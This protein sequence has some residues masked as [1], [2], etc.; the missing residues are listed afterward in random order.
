MPTTTTDADSGND[1]LD[2]GAGNDTIEAG[3]GNDTIT[4]PPSSSSDEASETSAQTTDSSSEVFP[5]AGDGVLEV[6]IPAKAPMETASVG[7]IVQYW[8]NA[9]AGPFPA[10]VT[11]IVDGEGLQLTVF[12][13]GQT[14][15]PYASAIPFVNDRRSDGP[16]WRWPDHVSVNPAP[17]LA[18]FSRTDIEAMFPG[19][20]GGA[21]FG[22]SK[23]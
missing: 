16:A 22:V 10:L 1:T 5:S 14:P 12:R 3:S 23:V 4:Q 13:P 18:D 7:R 17:A 21:A 6:E 11:G 8:D 15:V 20:T 9:V 19:A 2:S